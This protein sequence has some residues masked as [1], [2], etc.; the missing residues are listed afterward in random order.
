MPISHYDGNYYAD[1]AT[2][3]ELEANK[4]VVFRYCS[5]KGE[6]TDEANPNGSAHNIAGIANREGNVLGMMPHPERAAEQIL[7]ATDGS[8]IF[9]SLVAGVEQ[10]TF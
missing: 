9:H 8:L 6:I 5:P 2:L 3:K 7:G 4:Q 1:E 10:L